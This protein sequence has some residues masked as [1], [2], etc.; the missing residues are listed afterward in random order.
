M[1]AITKFGVWENET[2]EFID[3][4]C[5]SKEFKDALTEWLYS[6]GIKISQ[7]EQ[8]KVQVAFN[9]EGIQKEGKRPEVPLDRIV[10]NKKVGF[11]S[12][13]VA[14][15]EKFASE[16]G[17]LRTKIE[18]QYKVYVENAIKDHQDFY[19]L[20]ADITSQL[21][22]HMNDNPDVKMAAEDAMAYVVKKYAEAGT[23]HPELQADIDSQ[24]LLQKEFMALKALNP[25]PVG[26]NPSSLYGASAAALANVQMAED[27]KRAEEVKRPIVRSSGSIFR[28]C[29]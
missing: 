17:A 11:D 14:M 4:V 15:L 23:T 18:E 7:M 29:G 27:N 16:D 25:V 28:T 24:L 8:Q 12:V 26:A 21:N 13:R 20:Q 5:D 22:Q 6:S 3:A 19:K 9:N 10:K 1:P 2:R